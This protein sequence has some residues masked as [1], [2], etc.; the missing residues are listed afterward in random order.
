MNLTDA[1]SKSKE[2]ILCVD[3][4]ADELPPSIHTLMSDHA[5]ELVHCASVYE[6]LARIKTVNP[7]I[8]LVRVD[9]LTTPEFEF[10][11][12]CTRSYPELC[13]FV[14]GEDRS[15]A[16]V[17]RAIQAGAS[18]QLS[19]E[20]VAGML[21]EQSGEFSLEVSEDAMIDKW[22]AA[23]T[24]QSEGDGPQNNSD[25]FASPDNEFDAVSEAPVSGLSAEADRESD[26]T[27]A[28]EPKVQ[29]AIDPGESGG[30][31]IGGVGVP[32]TSISG[33]PPE[34]STANGEEPLADRDVE[35]ASEGFEEAQGSDDANDD[36]CRPV[37]VPWSGASRNVSRVPPTRSKP[38]PAAPV[39][40]AE[41]IP[42][43]SAIGESEMD[44]PPLL[45]PEELSLLL[46]E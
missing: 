26:V 6:A 30:I 11:S 21:A 42:G 40:E 7:V 4:E 25:T 44:D 33:H 3:I 9:W 38:I 43:E 27:D 45:S 12:I 8:A 32:P 34:D 46:G 31:E 10:F 37:I 28:A 41:S 19:A 29:S 23:S 18:A 17:D 1:K 2:V 22:S 16:K 36:E 14:V 13:I 24:S 5:F 15:A 20:A 35:D 39:E